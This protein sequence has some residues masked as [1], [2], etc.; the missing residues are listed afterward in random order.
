MRAKCQ[1]L[2]QR[3][4]CLACAKEGREFI[5]KELKR[6]QLVRRAKRGARKGENRDP[7]STGQIV[8]LR[9][10]M[11]H[12]PQRKVTIDC[13][14]RRKQLAEASTLGG[15]SLGM[16]TTRGGEKLVCAEVRTKERKKVIRTPRMRGNFSGRGDWRKKE[17]KKGTQSRGNKHGNR[18]YTSSGSNKE[19]GGLLKCSL[20]A[21]GRRYADTGENHDFTGK[22]SR[23]PGDVRIGAVNQGDEQE[24]E[25][26]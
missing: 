8:P 1:I 11:V 21:R 26:C 23:P 14:Q 13:C 25:T 12:R 18:A 5:H 6:D 2:F 3:R 22:L 4:S 9:E 16:S 7:N 10:R 19:A 20:E 24:G 15:I 17:E